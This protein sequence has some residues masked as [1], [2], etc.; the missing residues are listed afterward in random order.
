MATWKTLGKPYKGIFVLLVIWGLQ[1]TSA[2][3]QTPN[4]VRVEGIIKPIK[5]KAQQRIS[6]TKSNFKKVSITA[7][8]TLKFSGEIPLD[9]PDYVEMVG[10][11]N[12]KKKLYLI[13]GATA[14]IE[15]IE[16]GDR[17]W[18]IHLI[19]EGEIVDINNYVSKK[20]QII[21]KIEKSKGKDILRLS[22][23]EF[24]ETMVKIKSQLETL[25]EEM[26][27]AP[28]YINAEKEKL[29]EEKLDKLIKFNEFATYIGTNTGY[30]ENFF[31]DFLTYN[32]NTP[33]TRENRSVIREAF[34]LQAL[35]KAKKRNVSLFQVQKNI[36]EGA[37]FKETRNVMIKSMS[38]FVLKGMPTSKEYLNYI[39]SN[40][41]DEDFT[42]YLL[43]KYNSIPPIKPDDAY[44]SLDNLKTI[45][46]EYVNL[47]DFKGKYVFLDIWATWCGPCKAQMPYLKKLEKEY[48]NKNIVFVSLS[49]DK[50]KAENK[51][52]QMVNDMQLGGIQ[53]IMDYN[54]K[55]HTDFLAHFNAK[56]IPRFILFG[57]N[58]NVIHPNTPK[59]VDQALLKELF[60][61]QEI[62]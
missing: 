14:K 59:P 62:N 61:S 16:I 52:K 24:L 17:V 10:M 56:T 8:S 34:K 38:R 18:D 42:D 48:H 36:I 46:D 39:V 20:A 11:Y 41:D 25:L 26:K 55:K 9:K 4:S 33:L 43:S 58:G 57:P 28:E 3:A 31:D 27:L 37:D 49:I 21:E 19:G 47:S 30:P 29:L 15:I 51:W 12:I 5:S 2:F 50:A 6:F 45:N 44:P 13:P 35:H 7:D 22:A 60:D 54:N 40:L 32:L 53:L 23:T 1:I